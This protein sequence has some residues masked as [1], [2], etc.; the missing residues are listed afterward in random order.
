MTSAKTLPYIKAATIFGT[1]LHLLID[2]NVDDQ[3]VEH[4]LKSFGAGDVTVH[5]IEPT[6]EDVF[7]QLTE[8]RGREVE[9]Q[10]AEA[11]Q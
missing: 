4:D 7:V 10:R 5:P 8:T 11:N 3:K 2:A 6:L 1:S 9:A